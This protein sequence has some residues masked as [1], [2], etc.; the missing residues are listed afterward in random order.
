MRQV[1]GGRTI[2]AYIDPKNEFG[3]NDKLSQVI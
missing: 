1:F 2:E 3:K